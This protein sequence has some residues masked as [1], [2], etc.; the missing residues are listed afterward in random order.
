MAL[1]QVLVQLQFELY[2]NLALELEHLELHGTYDMDGHALGLDVFGD[3]D[4][5]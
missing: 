2:I 4:Y 1:L 3:G 5:Q